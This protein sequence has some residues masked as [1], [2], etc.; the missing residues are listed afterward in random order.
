MTLILIVFLLVGEQARKRKDWILLW[1]IALASIHGVIEQHL[2]E[3]EYFPFLFAVFANMSR[4]K[5]KKY[6][7]K[8]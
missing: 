2:V 4:S 8:K 3:L 1:I 6:G 7:K 5:E